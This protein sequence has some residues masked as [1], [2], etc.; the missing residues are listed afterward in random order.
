VPIVRTKG[1]DPTETSGLGLLDEMSVAE[2]RE[3]LEFNKMQRE[4]EL[5]IKREDNLKTK[6]VG[7]KKLMDEA[8]KIQD[9]R[10]QRKL[11]NEAKREQKI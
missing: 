2:L 3:R 5:H 9:A 11:D 7:V 10:E 4:Q 1:F 6:E 8:S